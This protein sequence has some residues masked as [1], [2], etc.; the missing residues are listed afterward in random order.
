MKNLI[1]LIISVFLLSL[2]TVIAAPQ[3]GLCYFGDSNGD[4]VITG[5]DAAQ[6]K[7][8][9]MLRTADYSGVTPYGLDSSVQ[10]VN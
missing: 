8:S 2:F 1:L 10:D 4:C 6:A 5:V 7:L 3:P 9:S